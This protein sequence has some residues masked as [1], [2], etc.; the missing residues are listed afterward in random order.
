MYCVSY[1]ATYIYYFLAGVWGDLCV[2]RCMDRKHQIACRKWYLFILDVQPIK[3]TPSR[4]RD[5]SGSGLCRV[6][7]WMMTSQNENKPALNR[8]YKAIWRCK[9]YRKYT[10]AYSAPLKH[11]SLKAIIS[12]CILVLCKYIKEPYVLV[13]CCFLWLHARIIKEWQGYFLNVRSVKVG[14]NIITSV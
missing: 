9:E 12:E 11:I 7:F 2:C 3:F 10:R 6:V 8:R 1:W 14:W 13:F 4:W 5:L